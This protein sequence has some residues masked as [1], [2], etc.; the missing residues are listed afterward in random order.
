MSHEEFYNSKEASLPFVL[1]TN[2]KFKLKTVCAKK[3]ERILRTFN[4]V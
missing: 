2:L 4:L 3:E 1:Q